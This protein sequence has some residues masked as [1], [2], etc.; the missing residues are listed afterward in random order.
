MKFP[1]GQCEFEDNSGNPVDV[2]GGKSKR[3][4]HNFQFGEITT[5]AILGIRSTRVLVLLCIGNNEHDV[6]WQP[7]YLLHQ[8]VA[9]FHTF[10]I[11]SAGEKTC[12]ILHHP[13][14]VRYTTTDGNRAPVKPITSNNSNRTLFPY[15]TALNKNSL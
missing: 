3:N 9:H 13:G 4:I 12:Q 1:I 15:N 2:L 10:R 11:R 14:E 8:R 5:T 7:T 6:V